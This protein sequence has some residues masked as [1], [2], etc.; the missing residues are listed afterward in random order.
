MSKYLL[1]FRGGTQPQG[2]EEGQAVMAA[3]TAWFE[4]IGSAV[5]DQGDPTAGGRSIGHDGSVTEAAPE[6]VTGSSVLETDS[7]ES[8]VEMARSCPHL[9]AGGSISVLA[10]M[11]VM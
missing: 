4:R 8:A 1:L 3:W 2:E 11:E 10:T 9:E 7:L 6:D 5:V